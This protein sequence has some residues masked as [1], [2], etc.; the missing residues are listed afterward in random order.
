MN[1]RVA[2]TTL[3]LLLSAGAGLAS[4]AEGVNDG[5]TMINTN[6]I[7]WGASP[8]TLPAGAKLA[9]L[10]GDPGKPG[11]FAMR[12]MM[13]AGYVIAPHWHTLAEQLTVIS[14]TFYIGMGD[15]P[16]RAQAHA[17]E[18]GGFHYLPGRAHHYAFTRD[19]TVVQVQGMGPFDI[20][21][22]DPRDDPQSRKSR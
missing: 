17:L 16:D 13:P 11:P 14:G 15:K 18:A 22:L 8:P 6:E 10:T 4:S 3:L 2:G 12:L 19:A 20:T 21:Y 7:T 1:S 5:A 9:V